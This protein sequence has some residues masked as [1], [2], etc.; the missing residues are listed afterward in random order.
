MVLFV[1]MH[2]TDKYTHINTPY[3]HYMVWYDWHAGG[4]E[5]AAFWSLSAVSV[6]FAS[7]CRP[8]GKNHRATVYVSDLKADQRPEDPTRVV[9][10]IKHCSGTQF[11]SELK[12]SQNGSY[13]WKQNKPR[14]SYCLCACACVPLCVESSSTPCAHSKGWPAIRGVKMQLIMHQWQFSR[15]DFKTAQSVS[16]IFK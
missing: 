16:I 8:R 13:G 2:T 7:V 1:S 15:I 12:I 10:V 6:E 5:A 11:S 3:T 4:R 14:N 9:L